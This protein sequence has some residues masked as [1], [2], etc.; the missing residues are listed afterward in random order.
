MGLLRDSRAL[1]SGTG[2]WARES[3]PLSG[4]MKGGRGLGRYPTQP[5]ST[6]LVAGSLQRGEK[7][8]G[9]QKAKQ[10]VRFISTQPIRRE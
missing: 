6:E 10:S 8:S 1:A 3:P 9:T 7:F 4:G 2:S 5:R